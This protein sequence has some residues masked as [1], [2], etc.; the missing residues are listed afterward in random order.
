MSSA[1]EIK[2]KLDIVEVLRE[3]IQVK[4]AGAN[5]QALCPFHREKSPSF[6][7]SPD[8]QIWHCF[9]CGKGG[10][11]LSFVQEME[12]LSFPDTLRLL[13]PK[14]GVVLKQE[15]KEEYS[16][17]AR[18]LDCLQA[19]A[20]Q[21][22]RWL[23]SEENGKKMKA[24]LLKR[25]LSEKTIKEWQV[26]YGPES[27]G[28]LT[29]ALK[30]KGFKEEE[31]FAAGLAGRGE[32]G[33]VYD[34]FRDRIVFP[35]RDANGA[36]IAFTARI[37]PDK[38]ETTPGGKYINS[39][40]TEVYDKSRVLFAL[41]R[42]KKAIKERD[43]AIVVEGQMDAIACHQHGFT[44]TVAS[45][46]TALTAEQL[47]LI[48]RF[49][50][51]IALS[52]DMDQAGQ[53]AADRG[54]H[55]AMA[56]D[57]N[58]KII[59]LPKQYKD[60]DDCLRANPEDFKQALIN[61]QPMMEYYFSKVKADKDLRKLSDKKEVAK[62]ML[63]MISKLAN[64]I[65]QDYW[66]QRLAESVG[67]NE[68]ALRESVIPVKTDKAPVR[69]VIKAEAKELPV[70]SLSREDR[71]VEIVLALL[72]KSPDFIHYAA[73][74]LEPEDLE[75]ESR[76]KFYRNLIIYYNK[77]AHLDYDSFR[78][79]LQEQDDGTVNMIDRLA[80]LGEK[81]YYN[82][83]FNQIKAEITKILVEMKK[84]SLKRRIKLLQDKIASSEASGD[85]GMDILMTEMKNLTEQLNALQSL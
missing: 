2:S 53:L 19:A 50:N 68:Q 73:S 78:L 81:D 56:L 70:E 14:A 34:R 59:V 71:L 62:L 32:R 43:F 10:D 30:A 12:G 72:L 18:I 44:N 57:I 83:D 26:G 58:I 23:E 31:I 84:F 51:N 46:G 64:K 11:V 61:S 75:E 41:D 60:P 9:G 6:V 33:S 74:H 29:T 39:P 24:Y 42:S 13:A 25:G 4:A 45:S 17:R 85:E 52:F 16:R 47:R 65:D 15:N 8:K 80:L 55:E 27:W 7:I 28:A 40:Q 67:I 22:Q 66:F 3:Y 37:N 49:S 82:Y 63:A 1:E 36:V 5:F 77:F 76:Q 20:E 38:A 35:I 69:P 21:Y 54:I 48:K 79:Y